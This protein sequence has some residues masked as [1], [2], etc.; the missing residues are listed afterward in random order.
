V[1]F[2][3]QTTGRAQD[4]RIVR[5]AR[6][7]DGADHLGIRRKFG[8]GR[9]QRLASRI[10]PPGALFGGARFLSRGAPVAQLARELGQADLRIG[11][12]RDAAMLHRIVGRDVEADDLQVFGAEERPRA[13]GEILQPRADRQHDIGIRREG[14]GGARAGDADRSERQIAPLVDRRL[15]GL[16]HRDRNAMP[17]GEGGQLVRRLGIQNAAA[18]DD[19]RLLRRAQQ[20]HGMSELILVRTG[21]TRRPDLLG[22]QRLGEVVGFR[23]DVLTQRQRDGAAI[24]GVGQHLHR[25]LERGNQ[26]LGT[27]DAVEIARDRPEAVGCRHAAV[28]EILDLLEDGVRQSAREHVARQEKHRQSID[29]GDARS[30]HE[31][32]RTRADRGRAGH[33]TAA[34]TR[35]GEGDRRMGHALLVVGAVGREVVLDRL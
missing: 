21:P 29:M 14:I 13:G 34:E 4:D 31:I 22:E 28:A 35:L 23:L 15:P 2:A 16:R 11:D 30:R 17:L 3:R 10:E 6:P 25:A 9:R 8:V 24:D 7:R 33:E 12:Q 26:L 19:H 20:R 32:E 27:L 18:G 1:Q 5:T